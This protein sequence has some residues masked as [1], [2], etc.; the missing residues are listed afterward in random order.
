MAK[1][2]NLQ[3]EIP[4]VLCRMLLVTEEVQHW[5]R[6]W[7]AV[8][9][10]LGNRLQLGETSAEMVL[11]LQMVLQMFLDALRIPGISR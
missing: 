4:N 5:E 8:A 9:N 2:E 11:L 7:N 6:D 1:E 3:N 10:I